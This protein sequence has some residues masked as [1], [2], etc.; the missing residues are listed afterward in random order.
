MAA[1]G[2]PIAVHRYR[3]LFSDGDVREYLARWDDSDVRA[4]MFADHFGRPSGKANTDE[5][6]AGVADLGVVY[7]YTPTEPDEQPG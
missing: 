1:V 4:F 3:V 7:E 5:K 6:I 2:V